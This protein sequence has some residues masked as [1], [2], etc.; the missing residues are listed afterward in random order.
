MDPPV[1]RARRRA[2][3]ASKLNSSVRN[4]T[5]DLLHLL[6]QVKDNLG[7]EQRIGVSIYR[8]SYNYNPGG[9]MT[10][11]VYPSGRV[12]SY[13]GT[14]ANRVKRVTSGGGW[15]TRGGLPTLQA[16]GWRA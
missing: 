7:S 13:E 3:V 6:A 5:P 1:L 15:I 16:A 2:F 14:E 12:V 11:M 8:F 10:S 9:L 4:P